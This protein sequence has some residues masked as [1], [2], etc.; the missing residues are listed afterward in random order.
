M[1]NLNNIIEKSNC[2]AEVEIS[3]KTKVKPSERKQIQ[4][5]SDSYEIFKEIWNH[6]N[7]EHVETSFLLLLNRA[8]KVLGWCKISSGGVAGTV[9][10][11]KV[12]FQ[13]ALN[14]NASFIILA[15]NHPSGN[16]RPSNAD[17]QITKELKEGGKLLDLHIIDHLILTSEG[18]FSM[19][20]EGLF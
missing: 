2:L 8:N 7:M 10:D 5:S 4:R 16:L 17:I 13:L 15:H 19:A 1:K 3:Y 14:A 20:D 11:K 12:V 18:Y 6:D 9:V